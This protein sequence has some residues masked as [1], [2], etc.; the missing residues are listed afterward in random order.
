MTLPNDFIQRIQER[1]NEPL[2]G[3]EAQYKMAHAIRQKP[4]HPPENARI[5]CTLALLYPKEG[6]WYLPLIQRQSND[7]NDRHGG[8]ISFPGG[9]QEEGDADLATTALREAEEEIG[10]RAAD[11]HV[12]GQLTE[13]YIPVSNFLVYPFIGYLDYVPTFTKQESEVHSILEVPIK[14]LQAHHTVQF[15]DMKFSNNVTVNDIPYYN[16]HGHVVWGATAMMLSEFLEI[17]EEVLV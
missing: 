13:L 11:V 14:L 7:P 12:L 2:P 1:L 15:T 17:I 8:Q 9:K 4:Q 6:K 3:P 16:V 5:A 10:I